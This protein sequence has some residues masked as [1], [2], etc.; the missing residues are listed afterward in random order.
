M[1]RFATMKP[2]AGPVPTFLCR[3]RAEVTAALVKIR[4]HLGISQLELDEIAGFHLG[5]TGKLERPDTPALPGERKPGR[6]AINPMFD[7]WIGAL[8]CALVLVPLT[9]PQAEATERAMPAPTRL[10]KVS[11]KTAR[12][13]RALAATQRYTR[14]E[15]AGKFG[16]ALRTIADIVELRSHLEITQEAA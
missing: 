2:K 7:P 10:P 6:A 12:R 13:I 8:G 3:N 1:A 15:L 4:E 14:M 5:Y 9:E 11:L 16:L